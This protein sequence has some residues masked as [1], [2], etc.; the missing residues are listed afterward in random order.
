[1]VRQFD[2]MDQNRARKLLHRSEEFLAQ[3]R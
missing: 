1:M 3:L 2:R